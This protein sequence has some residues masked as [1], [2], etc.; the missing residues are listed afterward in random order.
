MVSAATCFYYQQGFQFLK[1]LPVPASVAA[2]VANENGILEPVRLGKYA[3]GVQTIGQMSEIFF[4][5]AL[6]WIIV[7]VLWLGG[8]E[9]LL[10]RMTLGQFTAFYTYIVQLTW[11]VI[12]LGWVINIFQ[13]GTASLGQWVGHAWSRA[14]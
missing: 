1:D 12:A 3:A 14:G 7:L 2:P 10:H 4:L 9:V 13:R 5:L 8:R 11:P 6:P